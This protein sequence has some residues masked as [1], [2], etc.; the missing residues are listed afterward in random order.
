M[1]D[2]TL[3]KQVIPF[4]LMLVGYYCFIYYHVTRGKTNCQLVAGTIL[5]WVFVPLLA[6]LF[7]F[8]PFEML[9]FLIIVGMI[10]V[11]G[12][13]TAHIARRN[14]HHRKDSSV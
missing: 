12:Y 7:I 2:V 1:T 11:G 13:I 9:T 5:Y 8:N 6:S 4:L 10:G 3:Y 14:V